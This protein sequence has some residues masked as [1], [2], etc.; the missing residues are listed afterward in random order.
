MDKYAEKNNMTVVANIAKEFFNAI[1]YNETI[2]RNGN[3]STTTEK[4]SF[5]DKFIVICQILQVG[6][7]LSFT[8]DCCI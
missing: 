4:S 2:V 5:W 6:H 7:F 8:N 1:A 3:S